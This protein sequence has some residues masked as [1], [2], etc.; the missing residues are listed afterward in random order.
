MR[1]SFSTAVLVFVFLPYFSFAQEQWEELPGGSNN[2]SSQYLKDIGRESPAWYFEASSWCMKVGDDSNWASSDLDD[3]DWARPQPNDGIFYEG[4]FDEVPEGV[5]WVRVKIVITKKRVQRYFDSLF[6]QIKGAREIYWDGKRIGR[7]GRVGSDK[8]SETPGLNIHWAPVPER[9]LAPGTHTIAVRVSSNYKKNVDGP[10]FDTFKL[11]DDSYEIPLDL[12]N[13]YALRHM[14][15]F[16]GAVSLIFLLI[17]L[18]AERK[19]SYALFA[20]LSGIFAL[21]LYLAF[22]EFSHPAD[23][24]YDE[25][26]HRRSL[27]LFLVSIVSLLL[28]VFFLY[29]FSLNKKLLFIACVA[30]ALLA[31][32]F[33]TPVEDLRQMWFLGIGYGTSCL[34]I[35]LAAW[36]RKPGSRL[37]L[38]GAGAALAPILLGGSLYLLMGGH[39]LLVLSILTALTLQIGKEKTDHQKALLSKARLEVS[40]A[41]LETELIKQSIQPHFLMNTLNALI[42]WIEEEPSQGISMIHDLSHH[43]QILLKI[44]GKNEIPLEQEIQL[45]KSLLAIMSYR[46]EIQYHLSVENVGSDERIPPCILHTLVENGVTHNEYS[47]KRIEFKLKREASESKRIYT[48]ETP[49][50]IQGANK[51]LKAKGPISNGTGLKFVQSRLEESYPGNWDLW[52]GQLNDNWVT[53][54]EISD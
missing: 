53:R 19:T 5:F 18:F 12:S 8:E 38:A 34:L 1:S 54:I 6:N 28:P 26:A 3:S 47:R 24:T 44:S 20:S 11:T 32:F 46:K 33:S 48:M 17:F 30:L 50:E 13:V 39:A 51:T 2:L 45:C 35:I 25:N 43:F 23:L 40:K 7:S 49:I 22:Y 15:G 16:A 31:A 52:N 4:S 27:I 37:I 36:Q 14:V 42:D 29:H 9:L 10:I 41:R 21:T